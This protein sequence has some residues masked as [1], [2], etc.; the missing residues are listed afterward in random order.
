MSSKTIFLLHKKVDFSVQSIFRNKL[1]VLQLKASILNYITHERKSLLYKDAST[2]PSEPSDPDE[3]EP[4]EP[5]DPTDPDDSDTSGEDV[6]RTGD[7]SQPVLWLLVMGLSCV[8][9]GT[10]IVKIKKKELR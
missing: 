6:P 8:G 10:T 4:S 2:I 3:S 5:D 9:L 7:S 1:A